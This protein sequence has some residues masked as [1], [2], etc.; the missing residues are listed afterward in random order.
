MKKDFLLGLNVTEDIAAQILAEHGKGIER[1]KA[2]ATAAEAER[3]AVKAQLATTMT[4]L[5]GLDPA[6]VGT[7]IET[8]RTSLTAA[9]AKHKADIA[10]R[11]REAE[12]GVFLA[13]KK[14]VN[15]ATRSFFAAQINA[16]LETDDSRGKSRADI[17]T[18]LTT[19][20]DGAP[21]T[22]IFVTENPHK[23]VINLAPAGQIAPGKLGE[24]TGQLGTLRQTSESLNAHRIT[25]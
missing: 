23:A 11:D 13:D 18:A 6:K 14:F 17:L 10:K 22:D 25:S 21:M 16:A 5:N 24:A 3:D 7:E 12:T 9:E 19:G 4:A 2:K 20:E 1:E 8:L 15:A